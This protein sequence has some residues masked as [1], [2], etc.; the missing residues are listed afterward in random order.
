MII[1]IHFIAILGFQDFVKAMNRVQTVSLEEIGE[2]LKGLF[3]KDMIFNE[4][5]T[6]NRLRILNRKKILIHIYSIFA[7]FFSK[8]PQ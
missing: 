6:L 2:C 5:L 8:E 4:L 3:A 1:I 7:L